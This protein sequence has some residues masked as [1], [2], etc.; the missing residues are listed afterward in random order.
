MKRHTTL[1]ALALLGL[2]ATAG[3]ADDLKLSY[4]RPARSWMEEALPVGNGY[5]GA[6]TYG[7]VLT[8]EIQLS[9]ESI[10]AGGPSKHTD[11]QFGNRKGSYTKLP[12]VRRLL[13][14]G[15]ISEAER[16]VQQY[17]TGTIADCPDSGDFGDY[18]A[19][20]PFGSLLVSPVMADSAY[21]DYR[22]T[23]DLERAVGSASY[24]RGGVRFEQEYFASYPKRLVVAAYTNDAPDGVDYRIDF[25]STHRNLTAKLKGDLLTIEGRHA[26]NNLLIAGQVLIKTDGRIRQAKSGEVTV[27]GA[28]YVELYTSIATDYKNEYPHYRGGDPRATNKQ[29]IAA[30]RANTRAQ[31]RAEHEADYRSLFDRVSLRVGTSSDAVRSLPT[32]ERLYRLSQGGYDPELE[33]LY[34]QYGRYLLISS[35]RPGTM[36]AHLQGKWNDKMAP[37]WACDY[38]M[39]INLQM[40]YWPAEVTNLAECHEPLMDYIH[41]LRAPGSVTAREYFGARGWAVNTMNN[42]YGYTAPGWNFNWGYAPNSAA[43]LCRHVWDHY[44][45]S[46]DREFLTTSAYPVMKEVGQFW[47]DYLTEDA[48]STLV[49]SPSYSPEH[50]LVAIGATIDQ[51]IAW[52][53][54]SNLLEAGRDM[55]GE[56]LFLDSI[57]DARRRLSPLKIGRFGQLQEW[58]EDLDDPANRHRHVSHLYAVYPGKQISPATTPALSEAAQRSL[59]YRGEDGTGWSLGWKINL[60]ARFLDGNQSYK[61]I[62]N[63]LTPAVGKGSRPSH[64]GSYSNLLCA[65]PPFQIDGNMGAVSGMTEMLLQSHDGA[66]RLLPALPVAWPSGEVK[67]LRAAGGAEV[68]MT[69]SDGM[70]TEAT[71]ASPRGGTYRIVYKEREQTLTLRPGESTTLRF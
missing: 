8:D 42:A 6:M 44:L 39:N 70:L 19:Q 56:A 30:A 47:L 15:K 21:T 16:L 29:A 43:W 4:T 9:E 63:L 12:E 48:D 10:W 60:W 27:G 45:F 24:V 25:A 33:A 5:M 14:E 34:F 59:V 1:V 46:G 64:S 50:G 32:D 22:R 58:K 57:A 37:P 18:G 49:S 68:G 36:P 67:G 51:E 65:H 11:Y 53:L 71:I 13:R 41:S 54:F 35:S 3:A 17:F 26:G 55:P 2:G 40:I 28:R 69:W 23:L 7:G 62:R 61:M 20:Q 52:D 66:I 31:L 38:H